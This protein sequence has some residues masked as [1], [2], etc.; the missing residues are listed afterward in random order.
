MVKE[1]YDIEAGVFRKFYK[2]TG[3]DYLW[4][5]TSHLDEAG[6]SNSYMF[7]AKYKD[8]GVE[9]NAYTSFDGN[10][11]NIYLAEQNGYLYVVTSGKQVAELFKFD[12]ADV[13]AGVIQNTYLYD[14]VKD[15]K[16]V[17]LT[18]VRMPNGI[19]CFEAYGDY[20][21]ILYD[22]GVIRVA[23]DFGDVTYQSKN[24]SY[25]VDSLEPSKYISF[26]LTGVSA[27]GGALVEETKTLYVTA[28]NSYLY[29]L[30]L[31]DVDTLKIGD[32]L[33]CQTVEDIYFDTL[34]NGLKVYLY[35]NKNMHNNYVTFTTKYGS[36]NNEF[37]LDKD[38]K[39]Y[40]VP[41][42]IA[43][44]L[45][46]KVFVQEHDPQPED[47]FARSGGLSNAYTTFKN[48]T[49]L[50]SSC[51]NVVENVCFLLDF[52]Q[53]IYLT[54]ENVES[55]KGII[56]QEINMCNDRP[57]DLLYDTIRKNTIKNNPFKESIIGTIDEVNSITKEMKERYGVEFIKKDVNQGND[58]E[59]YTISSKYVWYQDIEP[60]LEDDEDTKGRIKIYTIDEENNQLQVLDI[61]YEL[62]TQ[63]DGTTKREYTKL[64]DLPS[65][66]SFF[67]YQQII[68]P[69]T[70]I[71][72][73]HNVIETHICRYGK[74]YRYQVAPNPIKELRSR[75]CDN[76]SV[77]RVPGAAISTD[78]TCN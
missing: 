16:K 9:L 41:N 44:F 1:K 78:F 36:I 46:H 32:D 35:V 15:G 30:T 77:G 63:K 51:K 12:V 66:A 31:S 25:K 70:E 39:F 20:L 18:A 73:S 48:T 52:V 29:K 11:D 2:E 60:K 13:E 54:D 53:N 57:G 22:A 6:N 56:T 38:E 65:T 61:P 64:E 27:S 47:Y 58:V 8:G 45:E 7:Q 67:Q 40:K 55:E 3:S 71:V 76:T 43:H 34:E 24:S 19:C 33:K 69:R 75:T 62:K 23:T 21:Y 50:F 49:Y 42:G 37:T 74:D 68:N 5:F 26:G 14:C 4:F 59:G 10:L 17:K 28:R 72:P